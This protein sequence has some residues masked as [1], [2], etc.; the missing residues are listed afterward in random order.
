MVRRGGR[1]W[2]DRSLHE[3]G[4]PEGVR[5]V[6]GRRVAR[7]STPT[8]ALLRQA[9]GFTADFGF[10]ALGALPELAEPALLDCSRRTAGAPPTDREANG[11]DML[12]PSDGG[13]H[14]D[15]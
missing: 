13:G 1:W 6:V 10:D 11:P 14:E 7:L 15:V 3:L 2:T 12:G 8:G 9:A 4:I 5:R